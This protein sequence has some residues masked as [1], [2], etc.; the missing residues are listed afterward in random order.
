SWAA[1]RW[2]RI[3]CAAAA[4]AIF[5]VMSLACA[6]A[7]NFEVLLT[8]RFLEGIGIG[9][10]MPVAAVYINELSRGRGRGRSFLLYEMIFPV[11]LMAAGQAGAVLV[12][13]YGWQTLFLIGGIPALVI[14][15][16]LLRLPESPRWLIGKGRLADADAVVSQMEAASRKRGAA[17]AQV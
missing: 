15:L 6:A 14:A 9:G 4:T 11:G 1:Q 7:P 3:R 16:L 12:P 8:C 5:G 13:L 10:E 17:P 2:G